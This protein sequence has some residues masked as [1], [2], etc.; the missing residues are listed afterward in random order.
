[1]SPT[2]TT[3]SIPEIPDAIATVNTESHAPKVR[4]GVE[5]FTKQVEGIM[6]FSTEYAMKGS[7]SFDVLGNCR[8]GIKVE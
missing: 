2:T 1:L 6:H 5:M 3:L 4:D 7:F 8:T